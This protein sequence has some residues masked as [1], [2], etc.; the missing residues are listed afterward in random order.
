MTEQLPLT[1]FEIETLREMIKRHRQE[2][3]ILAHI[4]QFEKEVMPDDYFTKY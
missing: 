2:M 4:E 1:D 3:R